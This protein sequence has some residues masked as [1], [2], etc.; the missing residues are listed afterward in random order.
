MIIAQKS[1]TF[2]IT[3]N[4]KQKHF[5]VTNF[6]V[7]TINLNDGST[8]TNNV[9]V[10][11][12][13]EDIS[14]PAEATVGETALRGTKT[15]KVADGS[16]L[17]DGM[18]FKDENGNMYY[19]EEINGD[20]ITTKMELVEDIAYNSKLTQVGNTGIYKVPMQIDAV[21]KYNVVISNPGVNLRNLATYVDVREHSIDDVATKIDN[22]SDEIISKI[23]EIKKEIDAAD[24][25]DYEVVG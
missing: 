22:K 24:G 2:E 8:T 4:S 18:V 16:E 1:K 13:I 17:T 3:I 23:E 21:S 25:S 11:E 5:G 12:V 19:I 15:I 6:I 20:T 9:D 7:K 14:D 10:T